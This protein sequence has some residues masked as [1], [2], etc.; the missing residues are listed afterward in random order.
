MLTKP[1]ELIGSTNKLVSTP[2]SLS[3]YGTLKPLSLMLCHVDEAPT[4]SHYRQEAD[5]ALP[6]PPHEGQAEEHGL[7]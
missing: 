2:K 7:S 6:A 1:S 5:N 3:T 4:H